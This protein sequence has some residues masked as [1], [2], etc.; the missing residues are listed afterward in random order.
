MIVIPNRVR[1]VMVVSAL[2][3]AAGLL[4]LMSPPTSAQQAPAQQQ[5]DPNTTHQQLSTTTE[6][7]PLSQG[8]YNQCTGEVFQMD[9]SILTV[10]HWTIDGNGGSHTQYQV[11]TQGHGES[12][13]TGAKY[14]YHNVYHGTA[15]FNSGDSF[16]YYTSYVTT[17]RRQGSTTPDDDWEVTISLKQTANANGELTTEIVKYEFS[18]K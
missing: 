7:L 5:G 12:L 10:S 16:T 8:F 17:M 3:L 6:R 4:T 11:N 13:T 14:T 15:N 9:G 1:V 2:A 18:C